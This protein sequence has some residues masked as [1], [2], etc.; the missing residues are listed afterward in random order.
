MF[1]KTHDI[2]SS[3]IK[4]ITPSSIDMNWQNL[5]HESEDEI[6]IVRKCVYLGQKLIEQCYVIRAHVREKAQFLKIERIFRYVNERKIFS[7]IK[8]KKFNLSR[9]A[10]EIEMTNEF[11]R[12][13]SL[14]FSKNYKSYDYRGKIY[15]SKLVNRY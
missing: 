11:V 8:T 13:D 5:V 3:A 12:I 7:K 4:K 1:S 6:G 2:E 10:Y 15:I 9:F 14:P